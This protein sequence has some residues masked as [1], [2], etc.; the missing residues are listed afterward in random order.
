[1]EIY[2]GVLMIV[3][4]LVLIAVGMPIALSL[5]ISG[6][7]CL[8][9]VKGWNIT[10]GF[11]QTVPYNTGFNWAYVVL[12]LFILM[13][14]LAFYAGISTSAFDMANKWFGK[15]KGGLAMATIAACG[16]FGATSGSSIA[17]AAA[18]GKVTIPEMKK[19]NYSIELAAGAVAAGGTLSVMIPPSGIL[20][21]YG[22]ITEESIGKLL[23]AGILPGILSIMIYCVGISIWCRINPTLVPQQGERFSWRERFSSLRQSY[24]V[25]IIFGIVVGGIYTGLATPN[26]AS[27][28]GA[29]A[30]LILLLINA[31]KKWNSLGQA[32][33]STSKVTCMFM[34]IVVC[35]AF[36]TLGLTVTGI[37][38]ALTDFLVGLDISPRLLVFLLLLPYIPLG[39][40]LDTLSMMFITLPVIFPVIKALGFSGI[41]FGILVT[42]LIEVSLMTPPLGLNVY[43]IN[44]IMPDVPLGKIFRGCIPFLLMDAVTLGL[45][46]FIPEI[47]TWLPNTMLSQ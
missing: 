9:V 2:V 46:F 25:V 42:K 16:I 38:K 26:E 29:L 21:I 28:F 13:G 11:L 15:I 45:L 43:V 27:A 31:S 47:S 17:A 36:F 37:P 24:G 40:F 19:Y 1:M 41:W 12:P 30:A 39:M 4:L 32:L 14:E 35:A 22:L 20:V 23:I 7:L 6:V 5:G 34:L 8:L 3:L 18:M 44:G 33:A 10:W